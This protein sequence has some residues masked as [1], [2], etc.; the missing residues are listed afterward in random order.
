MESR[1]IADHIPISPPEGGLMK[2]SFI[3]CDQARIASQER[4]NRRIGTVTPNTLAEVEQ[5][6]RDFIGL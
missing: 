3:L 2:A 4:L 1:G 6:L 5:W